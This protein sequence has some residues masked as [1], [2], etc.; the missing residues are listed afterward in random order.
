[1]RVSYTYSLLHTHNTDIDYVIHVHY[2]C[3]SGRAS[4][5]V[6]LTTLLQCTYSAIAY[7]SMLCRREILYFE[8]STQF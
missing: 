7:A 8:I 4:A 5:R 2:S 1:M 3:Y 6:V